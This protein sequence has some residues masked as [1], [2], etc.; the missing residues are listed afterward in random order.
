MYEKHKGIQEHKISDPLTRPFNR[1]QSVLE[2]CALYQQRWRQRFS[3]FR[4][5]LWLAC[6]YG[7]LTTHQNLIGSLFLY[8]PFN[9]RVLA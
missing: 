4:D 8:Y 9:I 7:A 5:T 1:T 3:H 6:Y 2:G